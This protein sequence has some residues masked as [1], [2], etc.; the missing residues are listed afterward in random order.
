MSHPYNSNEEVQRT[1]RLA[2]S[3]EDSARTRL[4][5]PVVKPHVISKHES[6]LQ[7]AQNRAS[8]KG[9]DRARVMN[10]TSTQSTGEIYTEG[11]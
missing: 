7:K 8:I 9:Y 6:E 10:Q 5:Q 3:T 2:F 4:S 11:G 1:R